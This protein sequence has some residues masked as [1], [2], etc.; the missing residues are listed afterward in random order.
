MLIIFVRLGMIVDKIHKLISLKESKWLE[1]YIDSITQKRNKAKNQFEKDF[2]K[3]SNNAFYGKTMENVR[4]RLRSEIIK[5]QE[6]KKIKQQSRPTFTGIQ[7]FFENCD[8]CI[9]RKN[10]VLMDKPIY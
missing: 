2:C 9:F 6:F 1:K 5:N 4:N 10:E 8:S 7:N 3:L